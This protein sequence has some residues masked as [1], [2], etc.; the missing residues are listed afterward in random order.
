MKIQ[1][2][3]NGEAL[4][5]DVD[6]RTLLVHYIREELRLT[7]THIGCDT[8]QC[9]ACTVMVDG[10]AVKSCTGFAVQAAGE[11]IERDEGG[12]GAENHGGTEPHPEAA[13]CRRSGN[14]NGLKEHAGHDQRLAPDAI[15][16]GAGK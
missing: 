10:L 5:D 3:V 11:R 12:S 8:S 2:T 7:G 15:R 9:G 13:E 14:G 16:P 6:P 1:T 4:V